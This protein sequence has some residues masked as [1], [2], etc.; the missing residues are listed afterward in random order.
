[1]E[2]INVSGTV[3]QAKIKD[4]GETVCIYKIN[5]GVTVA[6]RKIKDKDETVCI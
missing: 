4:K 5:V 6:H 1:M 3:G 2:K